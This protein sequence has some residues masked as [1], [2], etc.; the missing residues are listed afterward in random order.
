MVKLVSGLIVVLTMSLV[1][2]ASS[3]Q[4]QSAPSKKNGTSFEG[5]YAGFGI[6]VAT[7]SGETDYPLLSGGTTYAPYDPS[8]GNAVSGF[9]GYNFVRGDIVYGAEINLVNLQQ[10]IQADPV[11]HREIMDF[12]DVR[13]RVGRQFDTWMVYGG[14]R[15]VLGEVP[16][17]SGNL[18]CRPA[19][20]DDVD[21]V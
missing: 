10:L 7:A 11:E 20:P 19:K 16:G 13:A 18:F 3:A 17:S 6:G 8:N 2:G 5:A 1:A 21:G 14:A 15:V 4:D 9:A 12:A